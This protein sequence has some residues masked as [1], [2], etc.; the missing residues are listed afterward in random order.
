MLSFRSVFLSNLSN[1]FFQILI[2]KRLKGNIRIF[3]YRSP[4]SLISY[5]LVY[6]LL[7]NPCGMPFRRCTYLCWNMCSICIRVLKHTHEILH[8]NIRVM[9]ITNWIL[10]ATSRPCSVPFTSILIK[11]PY[12]MTSTL[13]ANPIAIWKK[14]FTSAPV[15]SCNKICIEPETEGYLNFK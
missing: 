10:F 8:F 9:K 3:A 4:Y 7:Q 5:Y 2:L 6:I 13:F 1:F 12:V 15:A 11:C 14:S